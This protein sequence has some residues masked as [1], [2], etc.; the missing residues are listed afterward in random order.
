MY[1]PMCGQQMADGAVICLSCGWREPTR[2]SQGIEHDPAMRL[3]MPIGQ[4]GWAI[5]AGYF[6]L[7]SLICF[8]APIAIILGIIAL[9]DIKKHPSKGGKGRAI[10]GLVMGTIATLT[11]VVLIVAGAM[12]GQ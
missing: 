5:A 9:R 12:S 11:I 6:G 10:F 2:Q 4:S 7:F 8:P 3:L 1:C